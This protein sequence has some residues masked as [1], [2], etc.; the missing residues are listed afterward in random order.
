[1]VLVGIAQQDDRIGRLLYSQYVQRPW[2]HVAFAFPSFRSFNSIFLLAAKTISSLLFFKMSARSFL[3]LLQAPFSFCF[4]RVCMT[5]SPSVTSPLAPNLL[6]NEYLC[7]K[8]WYCDLFSRLPWPCS[9][10][11]W[12]FEG[13]ADGGGVCALKFWGAV[14]IR[15]SRRIRSVVAWTFAPFRRRSHSMSRREYCGNIEASVSIRSDG[16]R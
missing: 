10:V 16:T 11:P 12:L 8:F 3:L 2:T 5:S 6:A 9:D 15:P 1:M 7:I 14:G 13:L 4:S